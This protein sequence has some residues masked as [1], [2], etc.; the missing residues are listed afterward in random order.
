MHTH[1]SLEAAERSHPLY[2]EWRLTTTPPERKAELIALQLEI[3]ATMPVPGDV[4]LM[5]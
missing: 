5:D 3:F 4:E 1:A 2:E